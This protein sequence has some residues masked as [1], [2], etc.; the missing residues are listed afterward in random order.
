[1]EI[2][3]QCGFGGLEDNK[4]SR[5]NKA[6]MKLE[7]QLDVVEYSHITMPSGANKEGL[8]QMIKISL[9]T[10]LQKYFDKTMR[11]PSTVTAYLAN[12][13]VRTNLQVNLMWCLVGIRRQ[14]Y[15]ATIK[16]KA[17]EQQLELV[18]ALKTP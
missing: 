10:A 9:R 6:K 7:V 4:F 8:E 13:C 11:T 12:P 15:K 1:M 3:S 2:I 14:E 5:T 17:R 16:T 18:E